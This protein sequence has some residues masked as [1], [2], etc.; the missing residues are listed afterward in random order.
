MDAVEGD[1]FVVTR[2]ER[3]IGELI[4]L[5]RRHRFVPRADVVRASALSATVDLS[6]FR[7]DQQATLPG[8]D[9]LMSVAPIPPPVPDWPARRVTPARIPR[10]RQG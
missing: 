7:A 10:G 5:R 3:G 2:D 1:S 9:E 4:P 6:R 8:P